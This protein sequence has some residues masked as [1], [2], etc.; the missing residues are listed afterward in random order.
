MGSGASRHTTRFLEALTNYRKKKFTTRVELGDDTTCEIE[1]VGSTSHQLDSG[2][3][4]HIEDILYV[5]GLKNNILLVSRLEDKGY[6]LTFMDKK[7]IIWS[8]KEILSSTKVIGDRE[9]C[10]YKAFRHST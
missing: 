8:K 1:G 5:P 4:L 2:T 3:I 7:F 6:R 10:L 9:G